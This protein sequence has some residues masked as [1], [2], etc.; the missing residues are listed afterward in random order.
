MLADIDW[1]KLKKEITYL[2]TDSLAELPR[3]GKQNREPSGFCECRDWRVFLV[4][5]GIMESSRRFAAMQH[6]KP[7]VNRIYVVRENPAEK[8]L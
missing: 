1:Q 6:E 7:A 3:C 4:A 5:Q 2:P 8:I